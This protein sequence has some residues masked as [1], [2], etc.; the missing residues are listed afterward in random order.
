[1][2][3]SV[4]GTAVTVTPVPTLTTEP[5]VGAVIEIVGAACAKPTANS[6]NAAVNQRRKNAGA[7]DGAPQGGRLTSEEVVVMG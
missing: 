1:M 3:P 5:T 7:A 2:P 4:E 6:V